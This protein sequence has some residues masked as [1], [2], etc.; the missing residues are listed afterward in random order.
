[1]NGV[2]GKLPDKIGSVTE[3][4]VLDFRGGLSAGPVPE[5]L[6][7]C[8]KLTRIKLPKCKLN[9]EFPN[10]LRELKS[11]LGMSISDNGKGV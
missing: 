6:G 1:M 4:I 7:L 5:S 3:L 10:G 2:A 11:T 8:I 9:G